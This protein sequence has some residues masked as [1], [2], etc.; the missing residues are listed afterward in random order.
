MRK[1]LSKKT[2]RQTSRK[3]ERGILPD[4]IKEPITPGTTPTTILPKLE[5]V[6]TPRDHG[7]NLVK[8]GHIQENQDATVESY[9][10]TDIYWNAQ[11]RHIQDK[12]YPCNT[13]IEKSI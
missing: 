11:T 1:P 10:T 9:G 8:W 6:I 2:S 12:N 13:L 7:W 4:V 5:N 3:V